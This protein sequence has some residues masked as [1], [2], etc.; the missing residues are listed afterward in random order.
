MLLSISCIIYLCFE[1]KTAIFFRQKNWRK[2]FKNH[3][4][5]PWPTDLRSLSTSQSWTRSRRTKAAWKIEKLKKLKNWKTEKL[6][7]GRSW[8]RTQPGR[9]TLGTFILQMNSFNLFIS[10]IIDWKWR[11]SSGV[12]VMITI[13]C[14]FRQFLAEKLPF[15]SKT[16][17]M[18]NF[19]QNLALFW[20]KNAN[21]FAE[22]FGE[23]I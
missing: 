7:N 10:L 4:I 13:F 11:P 18:I 19:F 12:D 22:F 1:S 3:N 16:N 21:F 14:D 5:G 9:K 2:H 20:D 15:F 23:N 6:K 17:V 8:V